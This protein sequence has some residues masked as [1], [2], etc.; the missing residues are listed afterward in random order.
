MNNTETETN[1]SLSSF[2]TKLS[3]CRFIYQR[4]LPSKDFLKS[5]SISKINFQSFGQRRGLA[6][7]GFFCLSVRLLLLALGEIFE[8][9]LCHTF[10]V[11]TISN[12]TYYLVLLFLAITGQIWLLCWSLGSASKAPSRESQRF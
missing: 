8:I 12:Y 4:C 10:S 11:H 1:G 3:R 2:A 5:H 7:S 6:P 9:L